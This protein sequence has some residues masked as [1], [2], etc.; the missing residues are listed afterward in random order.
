[1]SKLQ[2]FKS[3]FKSKFGFKQ[4]KDISQENLTAIA[5][6]IKDEH[7]DWAAL[8]DDILIMLLKFVILQFPP[9]QFDNMPDQE[10]REKIRNAFVN[11]TK[12]HKDL[13]AI[14]SPYEIQRLNEA[15]EKGRRMGVKGKTMLN[16]VFNQLKKTI[17]PVK[18]EIDQ[19]N[20]IDPTK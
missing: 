5:K 2:E 17:R 14:A 13:K 18:Q 20:P 7:P 9:D 16:A 3:N 8:N 15:Y 12:I 10:L 6:M 4:R 19:K 11:A 1:M